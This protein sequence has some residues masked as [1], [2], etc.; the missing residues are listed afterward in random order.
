MLGLCGPRHRR[1]SMLEL[2]T[3]KLRVPGGRLGKLT[4][5]YVSHCPAG[6]EAEE[7]LQQMGRAN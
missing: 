1:I 4:T 7:R 3:F 6:T 2:E 5:L